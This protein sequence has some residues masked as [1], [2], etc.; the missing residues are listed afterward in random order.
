MKQASVILKCLIIIVLLNITHFKCLAQTDKQILLQDTAIVSSVDMT[1]LYNY[2]ESEF[3][4]KQYMFETVNP[5]RVKY[6]EHFSIGKLRLPKYNQQILYDQSPLHRGEYNNG[7]VIHQFNQSSILLG[8]GSRTNLVGLGEVSN[9]AISYYY[10]INS[11]LVIG[12]YVGASTLRAPHQSRN[13]FEIGTN[14]SYQITNGVIFHAYGN[15][16]FGQPHPALGNLYNTSSFGGYFAVDM[17]ER[18]GMGVGAQTYY[19]A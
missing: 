4:V 1:L 11:R 12:G 6:K 17:G 10:Q 3:D 8:G 5:Q 7:G 14:L 15:Y 18:F 13:Q 16:M 9:A 2:L 19:N